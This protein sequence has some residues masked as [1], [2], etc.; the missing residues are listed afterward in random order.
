MTHQTE[1][2][3]AALTYIEGHLCEPISLE[4]IANAAG[5]SL[6]HFIRTFNKIVRHTPYDYLVRR[7]LSYA[8]EMLLVEDEKVLDIALAC[9]FESHEGFTRAFG[10]LFKMPPTT[11]REN[12][13]R[14]LRYIM[15]PLKEA[16]LLFRQLP[17]LHPPELI[18]LEELTLAGW[19]NFRTPDGGKEISLKQIFTQTSGKGKSHWEVRM[20][21]TPELFM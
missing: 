7:R 1:A 17:D 8:A 5:Y 12:Q 6:F 18:L 2:I 14:D 10:R 11:W 13:H 9:Q 3:T 15:P 20:L 4:G 21:A 19:M 16:D